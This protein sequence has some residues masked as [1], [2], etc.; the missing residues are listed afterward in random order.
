MGWIDSLRG[1]AVGFDTM[2]LIYYIEENPNYSKVVDPFFEAIERGEFKVITSVV[3]L[4]E[5]LVHPLRNGDAILAQKYRDLLFD[6]EGL[7]TM[8]FDQEIAEEAARLRASF[9]IRTPDSIQMATAVSEGA[10]FFLTN[11]TRLPSLPN[12][13][14]LVLDDLKKGSEG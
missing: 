14:T 3:T 5:V 1:S 6:T 12:L 11:D 4:L 10:S 13:K 9:N 7:S 8:V 2:P